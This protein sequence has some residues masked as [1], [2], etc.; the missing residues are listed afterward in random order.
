[1]TCDKHST[2]PIEDCCNWMSNP[3]DT[4]KH[5]STYPKCDCEQY[6]RRCYVRMKEKRDANT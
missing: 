4:Y 5:C 6:G 3:E 1:M 2:T